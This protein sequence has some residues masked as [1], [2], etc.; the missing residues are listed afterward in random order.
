MIRQLRAL[1]VSIFFLSLCSLGFAQSAQIQ[2]QV[3]D[4]SGAVI[5]K[6]AVRVVNQQT[7]TERRVVTNGSGLYSV[8][9]LD[10]SVYKI[11]VQASGF[12]TAVSTS[13]TLNV[14]QNAV[15]NFKLEVGSEA[16][17]VTVDGS[18]LA[19]NTTDASVSIVVDRKFVE[20]MPLNGRS[21][22]DLISMTP[23][24][25][26]QS[27]QT[28]QSTGY[29]GD[30]SVNGQRTESN[31]YTI[32]GVAAN[33]GAGNGY[34]Q[35]QAGSGGTL[36]GST[37]LG[38]TQSLI[39]VDSLQEFRVSSSTYSAEYGRSPG[40]QF[41]F[42]TRSGTSAIHGSA[43]DY[44][45]NNVF[46]AND[47][48]ND[49]YDVTRPALRQNDFGGTLGGFVWL[50][51]I[52]NGRGKTFFFVSYEGL[53]LTLPQAAS[54]QYVPSISLRQSAS[55]VLTP[56]LN[57]FPMPTGAEA[58]IAC[59]G[60]T[61]VCPTGSPIG[62]PVPSGLSVFTG[63]S[64]LPSRIDS[65]S[66]RIDHTLSSKMSIFFRYGYTPS[67][68]SSRT[69]SAL[70]QA[71]FDSSSYTFGATNQFSSK[72]SN[73]LR[74]EYA[75][76][77]NALGGKLDA[78]GGATPIDLAAAMGA[79][80][81]SRPYPI[82]FIN[83][84]GVGSSQLA[85]SPSSNVSKQW[86]AVDSLDYSVGKHQFKF[87]FDYRRIASPLNPA[88]PLLEGYYASRQSMVTNQA[89]AVVTENFLASEPIFKQFAAFA[90]DEWHLLPSLTLS[91]GARWEVNPPPSEANG[92][93]AFTLLGNLSKPSSLSLAPRGTPLWR[94]T[95][96]NVAPRLGAAWLA[97]SSTGWETVVRAGGGVFFDTSDELG[98]R[99]YSGLGFT[100]QKY[101]YGVGLPVTAAQLE[102]TP[103]T[104]APYTSAP[105]YAYPSH[106]QL[107]YT[108]E[109]NV[110][111]QQ[112]LG[113]A[114]AITIS[115]VGSNGRRLAGW[116]QFSLSALN[117]NFGTVYYTP[118]GI[119]SNYQ[120]L[121]VQ[122]QRS[123]AKG[124]QA[125]GSY[126]WSHS[127]DVGSAATSLPVKR[128]NSDFDVRNNFS[129]GLSW[130]LPN[131]QRNRITKT[132]T[133]G[134]GLDGRLI[135]RTGFPLTV[136]GTLLVDSG[137]GS[138]YASGVNL[139]AGQPLYLYGPQ[140]PGG[141]SVNKAALLATGNNIGNEPRN[142]VRGFGATQVNIALRREF[143]VRE[144]ARFQFRAESFNVLNHPNFGIVDTT[145]TDSTFGQATKMLNQSLGTMAAQYQQ[146]GPRSLQFALKFLF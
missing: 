44:L 16:Q 82:M 99:G 143:H 24:V 77:N 83:I 38:T 123:V 97:H 9:G 86:N 135:A 45:R 78:F 112:A 140:Y 30:F 75:H 71:M 91:L 137:T 88:A 101:A 36:A 47:W 79:V 19:I 59:N 18:G 129:G 115:Y 55:S 28:S 138:L 1:L 114:Q 116:Q 126:T 102:L 37:A 41:S 70:T 6:A 7:G 127:I 133:S 105:V 136:G 65:T 49:H 109:W 144:Q 54:L 74:V 40:G 34:G 146:G 5:P 29:N 139:V 96:L 132:L 4:S 98:A 81:Y 33:T 110:S 27:P 25:V 69:L 85:I 20:N 14:A 118:G 103:S 68:T 43:F 8:P 134:W 128:G 100:A 22:Q 66:V 108:L 11:F 93:D 95:W 56:I 32:D 125:M 53:R 62:T 145:L 50:P 10:P 92:N 67:Q 94:T 113:K 21:F 76:A 12:S 23:G 119:T 106:L 72:V 121:Q 73:I 104:T 142:Y 52:Y 48:F 117:P 60:T 35:G 51:H 131:D 63:A 64:T 3:S 89:L 80:G 120:A 130:D 42:A 141:R 122:F 90:E 124:I 26:T 39:S 13:I 87:G 57:A 111:L 107:P 2:G 17:T 61:Y 84:A 31:Y 46:D 15:L 58:T